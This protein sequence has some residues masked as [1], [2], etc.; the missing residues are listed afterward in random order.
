MM[1]TTVGQPSCILWS[2]N[3]LATFYLF[4]PPTKHVRVVIFYTGTLVWSVVAGDHVEH[5]FKSDQVTLCD[6]FI[7]EFQALCS[8]R[9]TE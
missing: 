8:C 1:I 2:S 9:T 4:Y 7:P 5:L 3:E 6:I